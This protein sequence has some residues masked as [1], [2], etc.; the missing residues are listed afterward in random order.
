MYSLDRLVQIPM[1]LF[2]SSAPVPEGNR[3]IFRYL[4]SE[5][6]W[7]GVLSGTILSFISIFLARIGA[8]GTQI[9]MINAAPA[10][11]GL[12]FTLP[13]GQWLQQRSLTNTVFLSSIAQRIFYFALIFLP[14]LLPQQGQI[15]MIILLTLILSIPGTAVT[16]GFNSMFAD[17]VPVSWRGYVAGIRNS[18][19]SAASTLTTLLSG[20]IL[21]AL[22]FPLGYQFVFGIGFLGGMLSSLNLFRIAINS[23]APTMKV[24]PWRLLFPRA[25]V[26]TRRVPRP[27]LF[28]PLRIDILK[29]PI[30]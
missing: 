10:I 1:R 16:I 20:W 4:Y 28:G 9:G 5:I 24:D 11:I 25:K 26:K 13:I 14:V 7:Y 29:K 6:G 2:R 15:W 23:S 30:R 3:L 22:P 21:V 12:I 19:L 17:L 8:S 18:V 27:L